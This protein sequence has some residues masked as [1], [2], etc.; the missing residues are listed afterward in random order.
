MKRVNKQMVKCLSHYHSFVK[1]MKKEGQWDKYSELIEETKTPE[2]KL[3]YRVKEGLSVEQ[4]NVLF[5]PGKPFLHSI[6]P[7]DTKAG[8][9]VSH[10]EQMKCSYIIAIP[11]YIADEKMQQL[12]QYM[13]DND[14]SVLS[15]EEVE[16][17]QVTQKQIL[18]EKD[19]LN[20]D[21]LGTFE[22]VEFNLHDFRTILEVPNN[23][24]DSEAKTGVQIAKNHVK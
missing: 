21:R 4:L 20:V 2:G 13:V 3:E 9:Y 15:F 10:N 24:L 14:I 22:P 19:E 8:E 6:R 5:K 7:L 1:L 18:F 11:Q 17:E 16:K 23:I 12:V